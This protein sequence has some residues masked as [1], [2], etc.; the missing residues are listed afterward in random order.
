MVLL[1]TTYYEFGEKV[2]A[3]E[4]FDIVKQGLKDEYIPPSGLYLLYKVWGEEDLAYEYFERA[5]NRRDSHL[6]W[7]M[8]DPIEKSRIPD[9]PRYNLLLNKMGMEK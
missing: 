4:L 1:A 3:N 7:L 9:E 5:V 2:K 8:N 6:L